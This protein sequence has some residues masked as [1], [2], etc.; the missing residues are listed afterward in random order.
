[1]QTLTGRGSELETT[2]LLPRSL[3]SVTHC[4]DI[5][6]CRQPRQLFTLDTEQLCQGFP[7]TS[8]RGPDFWLP[9]A[10][11][12]HELLGKE[13]HP[14][15]QHQADLGLALLCLALSPQCCDFS[16]LPESKDFSVGSQ[17]P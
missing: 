11:S 8:F 17:P 1:M 15:P 12:A 2:V 16:F 6:T 13:G 10:P 9:K 3:S 7:A 4:L 14:W 5:R